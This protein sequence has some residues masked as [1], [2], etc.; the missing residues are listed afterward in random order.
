MDR[1][2]VQVVEEYIHQKLC[3]YGLFSDAVACR[4]DS[5]CSSRL[6]TGPSLHCE[7]VSIFDW[8]DVPLTKREDH[9]I[10]SSSLA[11]IEFLFSASRWHEK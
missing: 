2:L 10:T 11:S 1:Q 8:S 9:A 4:S 6:V 7:P 3:T 5:G